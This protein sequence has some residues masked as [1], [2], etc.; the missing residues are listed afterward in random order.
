[1]C[2]HART[3]IICCVVGLD[4]PKRTLEE[5][6]ILPALRPEV[7][8]RV[9]CVACCVCRWPSSSSTTDYYSSHDNQTVQTSV[10]LPYLIGGYKLSSIVCE[11]TNAPPPSPSD[12]IMAIVIWFSL[13]T[14]STVCKIVQGGKVSRICLLNVKSFLGFSSYGFLLPSYQV[15]VSW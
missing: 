3:C 8:M 9:C 1:M 10:S 14:V 13:Q 15:Y 6:V 11:I 5:I 2:V 7:N 4:L 12:Y